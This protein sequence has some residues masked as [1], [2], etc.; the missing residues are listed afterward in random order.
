M[1]KDTENVPLNFRSKISISGQLK[2][3]N[4]AIA[5]YVTMKLIVVWNFVCA[6]GNV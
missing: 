4:C 1:E 5:A 3:A 6:A 2:S